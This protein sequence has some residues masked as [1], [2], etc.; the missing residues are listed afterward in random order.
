[1]TAASQSRAPAKHPCAGI[2]TQ[3]KSRV[4]AK[5]PCAGID[6]QTKGKVAGRHPCAGID[7][8]TKGRVAASHSCAS[9]DPRMLKTGKS[10]DHDITSPDQDITSFFRVTKP[11]RDGKTSPRSAA[12]EGATTQQTA[13][14]ESDLEDTSTLV[15]GTKDSV[16][17]SL[18]VDRPKPPIKT[19]QDT[20]N[21]MVRTCGKPFAPSSNK[22]YPAVPSCSHLINV[23]FYL[24]SKP[25]HAVVQNNLVEH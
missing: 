21:A 14:I 17:D 13:Y 25:V 3:K 16:S 22:M 6:T 10:P 19:T 8:Q 20:S 18:T 9:V 2:D 5:H 23:H 4:P 12:T 24:P 7:T 11:E 15:D 1:M